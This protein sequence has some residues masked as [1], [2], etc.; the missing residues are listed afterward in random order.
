[1][2]KITEN[3]RYNTVIF[4][5]DGTLLNTLDDL[6][7]TMNHVLALYQH[8]TRTLDEIRSFVGNGLGKLIERSVPA[9][10]STETQTA[11]LADFKSYYAEH[12]QDKTAPYEGIYELLDS[13]KERGYKIAVVSN[14][15]QEGVTALNEQYFK[16]Y[17]PVGI[18][19]RPGLARK[20]EPDM[21]Y[22]AL[23][24]LNSNK[25]QAVYVGDSEVDLATARNSKLLPIAVTWGFRG[26]VFLLN[27]GAEHIARKP[28]DVL[29]ILE[30]LNK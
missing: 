25:T 22:A 4:D 19:E 5:C 7:D 20:P 29:S 17:F 30:E 3:T 8:P 23:D 13:L 24:E 6:A 16:G 28:S 9:D 14:K 11:M 2:S 21:V 10:T 26:E 27:Q 18:G 1:M 15:I 12:W